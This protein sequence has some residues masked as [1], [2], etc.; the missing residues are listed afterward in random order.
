MCT[1][2]QMT[3]RAVVLAS[4]ILA[5]VPVIRATHTTVTGDLDSGDLPKRELVSRVSTNNEQ[6]KLPA[7]NTPDDK[8]FSPSSDDYYNAAYGYT[9]AHDSNRTYFSFSHRP[10]S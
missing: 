6:R 9:L 4:A 2:K 3:I 5:M 8:G 1:I 7:H 10:A